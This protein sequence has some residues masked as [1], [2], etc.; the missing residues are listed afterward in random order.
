MR[1]T[2]AFKAQQLSCQPR[3]TEK[4]GVIL[5]PPIISAT[6]FLVLAQA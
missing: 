6:L 1:S 2:Y 4:D 3:Y 5:K